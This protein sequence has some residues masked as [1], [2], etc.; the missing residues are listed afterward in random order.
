VF[1]LV[2]SVSGEQTNRFWRLMTIEQSLRCSNN[3]FTF[4]SHVSSVF[5]KYFCRNNS[6]I[7][8]SLRTRS[9]TQCPSNIRFQNYILTS[10]FDLQCL[11]VSLFLIYLVVEKWLLQFSSPLSSW[12]LF[13][14]SFDF[15]SFIFGLKS[16]KYTLQSDNTQTTFKAQLK[17][18]FSTTPIILEFTPGKSS[19]PSHFTSYNQYHSRNNPL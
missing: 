14:C 9:V 2:F 11:S 3:T 5:V 7:F 16:W 10:K 15:S 18:Q 12:S 17:S 8:S 1:G 13:S 6:K 4:M 19:F